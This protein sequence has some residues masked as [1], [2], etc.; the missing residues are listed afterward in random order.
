MIQFDSALHSFIT[1]QELK[2]N[3]L[4]TVNLMCD[5]ATDTMGNPAVVCQKD[6]TSF[7]SG[8]NF[9]CVNVCCSKDYCN[10][11]TNTGRSLHYILP[12]LVLSLKKCVYMHHLV[13]QIFA[14]REST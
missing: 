9:Y 11:A 8:T 2:F 1:R 14:L 12:S 3:G 6:G 7:C 4:T 13:Q 5:R 10:L